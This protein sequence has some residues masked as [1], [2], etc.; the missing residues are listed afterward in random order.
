MDEGCERSDPCCA[1]R[2]PAETGKGEERPLIA[3]V[4][5][6]RLKIGMTLGSDPTVI[7]GLGEKFDGNLRKRDLTADTP[8]NTYTRAGLPPSPVTPRLCPA[9]RP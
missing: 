6:N 5:E 3:S 4:F 2:I 1:G 8:Y 9:A 7:Y